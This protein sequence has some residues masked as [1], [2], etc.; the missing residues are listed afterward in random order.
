CV[1]TTISVCQTFSPV[2]G[3]TL[4]TFKSC[5]ISY[6]YLRVTFASGNAPYQI[7]VYNPNGSEAYA[8]TTSTNPLD[9]QLPGLNG[10]E[11]YKVVGID[12]CGNKDSASIVPSANI[13]TRNIT[14]RAKCPSAAWLNGAGDLTT[15]CISNYNPVTPQI[16]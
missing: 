14:M 1:D 4:T 8:T 13:V 6:S 5:T 12:N 2:R 15:D 3:I 7:K 9:I 16:I 10:V 11:Q